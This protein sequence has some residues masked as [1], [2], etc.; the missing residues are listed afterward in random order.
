MIKQQL[1]ARSEELSRIKY[2]ECLCRGQ[3]VYLPPQ[4]RI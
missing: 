2:Q 4:K 1:S 3:W